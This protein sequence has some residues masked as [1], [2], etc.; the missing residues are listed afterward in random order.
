MAPRHDIEPRQSP[1]AAKDNGNPAKNDDRE[2][3]ALT[4]DSEPIGTRLPQREKHWP[5]TSVFRTCHSRNG[6]KGHGCDWL[7][8]RRNMNPSASF[9]LVEIHT[10]TDRTPPRDPESLTTESPHTQ[11]TVLRPTSNAQYPAS[12]PSRVS[13]SFASSSLPFIPNIV[14]AKPSAPAIPFGAG[15]DTAYSNDQVRGSHIWGESEGSSLVC[16]CSTPG[17][18]ALPLGKRECNTA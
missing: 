13:K 9:F 18:L 8:F 3:K 17:K 7:S 14:V 15:N 11:Q 5:Y 6:P 2:E 16:L 1:T 4:P 12:R 10:T